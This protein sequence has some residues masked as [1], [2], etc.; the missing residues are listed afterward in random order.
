MIII[1]MK[2]DIC[3]TKIE[4]IECECG[5]NGAEMVGKCFER[6]VFLWATEL[7]AVHAFGRLL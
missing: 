3:C 1:D 4:N 6:N 5:A 7:V 2:S